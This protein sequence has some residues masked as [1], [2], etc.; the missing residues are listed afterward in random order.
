[1]TR[2]GA[3]LSIGDPVM[4]ELAAQALDPVWIDLEPGALPAPDPQVPALAVQCLEAVRA[5]A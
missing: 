3:V 5:P 4:A 1:M 2:I